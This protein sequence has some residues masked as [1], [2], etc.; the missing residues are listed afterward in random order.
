MLDLDRFKAINDLHGHAAGDAVLRELAA[1]LRRT[2]RPDDVVARLGGDEFAILVADVEGG[3]LPY[4]AQRLVLAAQQP[5]A[6]PTGELSV[7]VSIGVARSVAGDG[8]I[9]DLAARAD[10][11]LYDVKT[12]G[13]GAWK[14]A[15]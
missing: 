2:V 9:A 4:L 13:R 5:V 6:T 14:I 10:R 1:R 15:A 8:A 3:A 11:A 12:A 7:G